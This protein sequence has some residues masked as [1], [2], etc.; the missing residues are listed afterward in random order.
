MK[1][2]KDQPTCSL[3]EHENFEQNLEGSRK[4]CKIRMKFLEERLM[5]RFNI[6]LVRILFWCGSLFFSANFFWCGCK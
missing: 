3:L 2:S 6:F 4:E 5:V 1:N